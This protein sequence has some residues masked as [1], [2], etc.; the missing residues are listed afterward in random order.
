M[1]HLTSLEYF[2]MKGIIPFTQHEGVECN[3]VYLIFP[4]FKNYLMPPAPQSIFIFMSLI[5]VSQKALGMYQILYIQNKVI[6]LLWQIK[7]A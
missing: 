3:S 6:S 1:N 5:F 4:S 2:K 7:L